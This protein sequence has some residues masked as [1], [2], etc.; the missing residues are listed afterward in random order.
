[1]REIKRPGPWATCIAVVLQDLVLSRRWIITAG[2]R[3]GNLATAGPPF[4]GGRGGGRERINTLLF[5]LVPSRPGLL[6]QAPSSLMVV[7]DP[8][9]ELSGPINL[10]FWG[11]VLCIFKRQKRAGLRTTAAQGRGGA[12]T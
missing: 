2:G 4:G 1:M 6:V 8:W 10:A 3:L 5:R 7:L 9:Q 11:F 12:E